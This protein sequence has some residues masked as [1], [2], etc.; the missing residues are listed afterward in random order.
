M[1]EKEVRKT[2]ERKNSGGK[3]T[4]GL[5]RE[6]AEEWEHTQLSGRKRNIRM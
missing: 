6:E 5:S 2:Q 1:A 3:W 4:W